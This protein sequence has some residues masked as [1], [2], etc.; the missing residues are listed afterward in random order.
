MRLKA[1]EIKWF[2]AI[3]EISEI[4]GNKIVLSTVEDGDG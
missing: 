4:A 3:E 1:L 2:P